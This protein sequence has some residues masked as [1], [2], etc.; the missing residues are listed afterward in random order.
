MTQLIAA[1]RSGDIGSIEHRAHSLKGLSATFEALTFQQ[2]A[3]EIES[4]A[5]SRNNLLLK[6]KIPE[7]E[8]EFAR[9]VLYLHRMVHEIT[10][11]A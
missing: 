1:D 4:L 8:N 11:P 9:L 3:G 6:S 7:L 10:L 2:L 5:R